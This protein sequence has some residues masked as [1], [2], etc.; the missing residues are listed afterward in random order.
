M[1]TFLD[2]HCKEQMYG[3][4]P[5]PRDC[6][7]YILCNAGHSFPIACAQGLAFNPLVLGC[8]YDVGGLCMSETQD[9]G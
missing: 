8:D 3:I 1:L 7:R 9:T 4:F 6:R 2:A 5:N